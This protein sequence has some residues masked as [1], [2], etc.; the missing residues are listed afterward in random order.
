[1]ILETRRL[2]ERLRFLIVFL[3]H[4]IE[5]RRNSQSE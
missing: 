4:D 1:V 2:E 5:T 3:R